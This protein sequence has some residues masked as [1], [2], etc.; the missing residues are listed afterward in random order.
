[1][2]RTLEVPPP[3]IC[4]IFDHFTTDTQQLIGQL[5]TP[6]PTTTNS[7]TKSGFWDGLGVRNPANLGLR[8]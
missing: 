8:S 4:T 3:E 2:L 7:S 6:S 1:M 5:Y